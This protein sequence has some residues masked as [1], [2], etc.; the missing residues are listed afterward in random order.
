M[1]PLHDETRAH[2]SYPWQ[3]DDVPKISDC[4]HPWDRLDVTATGDALP[5]CFA[6]ETLG[7][8][9]S[10]GLAGV[11]HGKRRLQL[12]E[13]VQAGRI[14][15]AC[16]NAPCMYAHDSIRMP[17]RVFFPP[18]RF[19]TAGISRNSRALCLAWP[20]RVF[21]SGPQRFVPQASIEARFL[22]AA[23]F[24]WLY[25]AKFAPTLQIAAVNDAGVCLSEKEFV[26]PP[27]HR[28]ALS[29]AFVIEQPL[30]ARL[31]LHVR[32]RRM[33]LPVWFEGMELSG[34]PGRSAPD[35]S[36]GSKYGAVIS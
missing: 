20:G 25:P 7:N 11:L 12:Q 8:V 15:P 21:V 28:F 5:C 18:D 24:W 23:P 3:G 30:R 35:A 14:N 1:A 10:D 16:F 32:A 4:P 33:F 22:F 31:S 26:L 29:L 17:W 13:D 2:A 27:Q 36:N 6:Q 19:H 9:R 34:T